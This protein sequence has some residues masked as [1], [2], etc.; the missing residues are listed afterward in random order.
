MERNRAAVEKEIRSQKSEVRISVSGHT[1]LTLTTH[2][3]SLITS[4]KFSGNAQRRKKNFLL[5]HGSFLLHFDLSL[6]EKFLAMPSLQPD[7]RQGRSHLDFIRNLDL[8]AD[9]VKRALRV[10]WNADALLENV[11]HERIRSLSRDK[12]STDEWNFKF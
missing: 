7:Y 8:P 11:P 12:Y 1:D 9:T 10:A 3:S 5:F 4:K 6:M 2:H